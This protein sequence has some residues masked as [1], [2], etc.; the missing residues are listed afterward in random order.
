M[1]KLLLKFKIKVILKFSL[2][3]LLSTCIFVYMLALKMMLEDLG[4]YHEVSPNGSEGS[5]K[6]QLYKTQLHFFY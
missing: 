2:E 6:T 3:Y 1:K 5:S 4:L